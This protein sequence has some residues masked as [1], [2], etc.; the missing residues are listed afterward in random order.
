MKNSVIHITNLNRNL[1]NTKSEVMV[2]FICSDLYRITVITNKVSIL[3]DLL[4]IEKYVKTLENI[5]SS[6]VNTPHLPQ[7]KFYLKII[8]IPFFPHRNLQDCLSSSNVETVIKQNQ[9]FDN[10]ILTSK[11]RV[12]KA[13]PKLDIV[14][15][16]I[17]I[18]DA[19]SGIKAKGLINRYFNV[20]Q[21]IVTIRAANAD[22]GI[23][24]CKNCWK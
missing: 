13:S 22:P 20:G 24:Q 9:I 12:I 8:G 19:Q 3:S 11:P 2:N 1:R 16:W 15:I 23:P 10:I 18:W 4:I 7:S 6:Q 17:D 21:Y 14:I 5:N